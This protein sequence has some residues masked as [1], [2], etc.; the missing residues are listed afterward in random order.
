MKEH[1]I[2]FDMDGTL[3]HLDKTRGQTFGAS[4]FGADIKSNVLRFFEGQ[5][6]LSPEDAVRE[7]DRISKKYDGEVSIGVEVEFG[8]PRMEYFEATWDLVPGEY[9]EPD[10]GLRSEL[11]DLQGR[12]AL[13]TAAPRIWALRVLAF[14]DV[15]D[16]FEGKIFTGDPD[17]RKPSPAVFQMIAG[18]L[19]VVPGN[20]FSIGDQEHSDILPAKSIGMKAVKIGPGETIADFQ[21]ED[22]R[23]AL[24]ILR[25]E[26]FI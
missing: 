24:G 18:E 9:I 2:I 19:G 14:L 7:Q 15:E 6:S 25:G 26:G 12:M 4:R 11:E 13:L 16:L 23:Q 1:K 3:Y 22:V 8:I 5:F 17:L 20:V 10:P 21:A